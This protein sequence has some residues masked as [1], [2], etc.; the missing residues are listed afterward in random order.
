MTSDTGDNFFSGPVALYALT[1]PAAGLACRY[2][3]VDDRARAFILESALANKTL[4][5]GIQERIV[6]IAKGGFGD[7][8][9]RNWS[10]FAGHIFIMATGIVVRRI[11]P[12]LRHKTSDPAVVVCDEKGEFAISLLSGHIG[13]A[14]RL[15]RKTAGIFGGRAVITTATDVQGLVAVD[16]LAACLGLEILNPGVIKEI[17]SL[18]LARK[19]LLLAG[20]RAWCELLA[21]FFPGRVVV[22]ND[23]VPETR[24]GGVAGVVTVDM[25]EDSGEYGDLPVLR[26]RAPRL[27]LGIGCR[28]GST[29]E[30]IREAVSCVLE[31]HGLERLSLARIASVDL[32]A[33]EPGLLEFARRW[34]LPLLFYRAAEL[35]KVRVP[36]PSARV[37]KHIGTPSVSEAAALLA[38]GG[39]FLLV[40]KNKFPRVTVAVAPLVGE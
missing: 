40:A 35:E 4:A 1:G 39:R 6:I 18:L 10:G 29:E 20:A 25:A 33:D 13:G 14:N 22:E 7:V 37:E 36:S 38:G 11:A 3:A 19:K 30:E 9:T 17:N 5:D 34:K 2:L 15:A 21:G 31:K 16:E 27:V 12:L 28:R 24:A 26:L 23:F 32:K 8:V